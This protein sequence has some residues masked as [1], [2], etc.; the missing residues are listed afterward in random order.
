MENKKN[1]K[2]LVTIPWRKELLWWWGAGLVQ[3]NQRDFR[4]W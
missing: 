3:Q 4:D 2:S 1:W